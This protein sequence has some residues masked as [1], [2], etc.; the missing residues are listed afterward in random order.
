MS[1]EFYP[2]FSYISAITKEKYAEIT[3]TSDQDFTDGEII[4]VRVSPESGMFEIN[5]QEA[6][7]LSHNSD[8]IVID[9]DTTNYT[10]F[11]PGLNV[12]RPPMV[13]PS[14]S[15]IIPGSYPATVNLQD[16]FDNVPG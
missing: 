5:N 1:H 13:V 7:V 12:K 14:A 6:R 9:I 2:R 4:G 3:F 8:S 15:G 16:S 10:T 11:I